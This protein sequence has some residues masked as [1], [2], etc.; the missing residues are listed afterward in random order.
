MLLPTNYF[1]EKS[2]AETQDRRNFDSACAFRNL[3][4][5]AT[6]TR[7]TSKRTRFQPIIRA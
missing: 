5:V 3:P 6:C 4:H 2:I 1:H 7:V